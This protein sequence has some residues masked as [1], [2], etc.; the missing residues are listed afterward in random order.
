ML[1]MIIIIPSAYKVYYVKCVMLGEA[2]REQVVNGWNVKL[3][4]IH[5]KMRARSHPRSL[6][7]V[8][9]EYRAEEANPLINKDIWEK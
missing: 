1:G 5:N 8:G 9:K 3:W 6:D 2:H 4:I 7:R